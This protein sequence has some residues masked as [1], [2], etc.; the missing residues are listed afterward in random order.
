MEKTVTKITTKSGK[1][2]EIPDEEYPLN[3]D[4]SFSGNDSVIE[5][6]YELLLHPKGIGFQLKKH[7]ILNTDG[8]EK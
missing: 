3:V 6:K 4:K 7:E 2:I 8:K 5:K 1:V